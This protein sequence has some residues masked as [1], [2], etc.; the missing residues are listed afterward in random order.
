MTTFRHTA[1]TC[2]KWRLNGTREEGGLYSKE[3]GRC[4][5]REGDQ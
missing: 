5:R 1:R 4:V 2:T 3:E